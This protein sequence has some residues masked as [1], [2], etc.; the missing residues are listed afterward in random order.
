MIRSVRRMWFSI[1]MVKI[2]LLCTIL[3][4]TSGGLNRFIRAKKPE[5]NGHPVKAIL[6]EEGNANVSYIGGSFQIK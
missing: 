5:L 4:S 1:I 6:Q 3:W 2:C